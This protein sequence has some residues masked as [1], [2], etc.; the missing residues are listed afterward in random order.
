MKLLHN[1]CILGGPQQN[2]QNQICPPYLC[3][4][5]GGKRGRN[6]G[7]T[8]AFLG[9]PNKE[10]KNRRG[11]LTPA[12]FGG[13]KVGELLRN[14]CILGVPQQRGTKS[15]PPT[16]PQR[17]RHAKGGR[18]CYVTPAF[19][20]IPNK[21]DEIRMGHL[22]PAFLGAQK[23][24]ELL[25]DPCI[26]GGPQQR[27]TKSQVATSYLPSQRPKSG[28]NRYITRAF[29]VIPKTREQ[30][31]KWLPHPCVLGGPKAGGN[32]T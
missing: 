4:G 7:V 31:L 29:A 25:C 2:K 13:P 24:A 9:M 6:R 3:G 23:W 32:A 26:L 14:P 22:T 15:E 12:F 5:V 30:N 17:Y 18:K 10:D 19:L 20:G 21:G 11:C 8:P 1:P 28:R 16:S 27:G